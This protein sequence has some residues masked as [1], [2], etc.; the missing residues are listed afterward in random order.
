MR[1]LWKFLGFA[2]LVMVV[3]AVFWPVTKSFIVSGA[4]KVGLGSIANYEQAG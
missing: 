3:V 2:L 1:K 4:T